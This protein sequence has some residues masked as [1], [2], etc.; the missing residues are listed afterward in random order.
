MIFALLIRDGHWNSQIHPYYEPLLLNILLVLNLPAIAV[1]ER[2]TTPPSF[3]EGYQ[4]KDIVIF[5]AFISI[6]WLIIGCIIKFL[7]D[8]LRN[9]NSG[10][11]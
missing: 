7:R 2:L 5:I 3:T 4:A 10:I 11:K 9:G 8:F 1:S 6:Q